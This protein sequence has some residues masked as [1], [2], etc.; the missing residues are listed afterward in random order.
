MPTFSARDWTNGKLEEMERHLRGIYSRAE[1][2]LGEAWKAYMEKADAELERLGKAYSDA[3]ETGD[4]TLIREAG[5]K[6]AAEKQKQTIYNTRY[7]ALTKDLAESISK[8]NQTAAAYI[9]GQLPQIYAVNYNEVAKVAN[10][11]V[12]AR[13][14]GR[15]SF[16]LVDAATIKRL[17]TVEENLLPFR[18]I[19]GKKDVR[20][21]VAKINAEV[22]QG[23]LQGESIPNIS[24][25]L[26]NVLDMDKT[27]AIRNARTTV[28]SAENK[29]RI[30]MMHYAAEKGVIMKKGW[31]AANDDRTRSSHAALDG[32][33]VEMDEPFSNGL[34][35]PGDP[36]GE[37]E[38][39]YNCFIG[40]T[41]IAS[42]SEIVRSYKHEYSGKLVTVKTAG[43]VNF[44]CT[45]NHPILTVGGWV[46]AESLQNG[47]NLIVTF[48]QKDFSFRINPDVNHAFPRID[49][50]HEFLDK[51]G[52]ERACSLS[53]DFHGDI[54]TSNVEIITKKGLLREGRNSSVFNSINKFLL[55]HTDKSF[56]RDSTLVE[57]FWRVCK[58]ALCIVSG[59]SKAFPLVWCSLRHSEIHRFRPIALLYSGRVKPL[60]NDVTRNAELLGECLNG[61]SGVVFADNIVSV[62]FN[63]GCSHVYNLQTENGYYFVNSSIAQREGKSNGI[64]AIAHNCRCS[65]VYDVVGFRQ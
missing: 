6:L 52:G 36:D 32:D 62:D 55:K 48:G 46:K 47:D 31:S 57:H 15:T 28:T 40:E 58:S 30:D 20:W 63:S 51:T 9:N 25:R 33:F 4:K 19:N 10:K 43:G 5:K 35:Y 34:M 44:T 1:K 39:V 61:F 24:K 2:E 60:N 16:E 22:T 49:A 8:V 18:K 38:E 29:G 11:A 59:F 53:V 7:Q 65:L 42:D 54:P 45:P 23:I 3:K 21:N 41:N 27:S 13:F 14:A 64:F 26:S 37:P 56:L 50:I 12:T 17:S